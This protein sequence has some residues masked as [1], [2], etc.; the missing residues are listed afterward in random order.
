MQNNDTKKLNIKVNNLQKNRNRT[1]NIK[2][3]QNISNNSTP[4]KSDTET[5]SEFQPRVDSS[6]EESVS[7]VMKIKN[8]NK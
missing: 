5:F 1:A 8:P 7:E 2:F 3:S 4:T 6:D